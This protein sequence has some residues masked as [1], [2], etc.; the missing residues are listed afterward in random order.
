MVVFALTWLS[1]RC[2][3]MELSEDGALGDASEVGD[4]VVS[5]QGDVSSVDESVA[6]VSAVIEGLVEAVGEAGAASSEAGVERDEAAGA[7]AGAGADVGGEASSRAGEAEG[8]AAPAGDRAEPTT[9]SSSEAPEPPAVEK[10]APKMVP[11]LEDGEDSK[12]PK[13]TKVINYASMDAGAIVLESS[14]HSKGFHKLLV[15]DKDKYGITECSEKKMV[16][17]GLSEDI[18]M[19]E[20]ILCQYEKYSSG[21]KE[22]DVLG[23]Q[24]F[25]TKEWVHLG[26]FVAKSARGPRTKGC[27]NRTSRLGVV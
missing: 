22:F 25:P 10:S 26:T 9:D 14:E 23:S 5:D 17:I 4:A 8:R 19:R 27:F 24:A 13:K 6:S 20:L 3:H 18:Q 1:V 21:V 7:G 16:V 15:D 11:D 12:K 2:D